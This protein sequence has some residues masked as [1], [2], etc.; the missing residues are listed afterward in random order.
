MS[1]YLDIHFII[2]PSRHRQNNISSIRWYSLDLHAIR[3]TLA[4]SSDGGG[5]SRN[6]LIRCIQSYA[7]SDS[8]SLMTIKYCLFAS[9]VGSAGLIEGLDN[10]SIMMPNIV[11][12]L[13]EAIHTR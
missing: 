6:I 10:F 4:L 8:S 11:S 13:E 7:G 5:F 12:I 9:L 1:S 2:I 3:S